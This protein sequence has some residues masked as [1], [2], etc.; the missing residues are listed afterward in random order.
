MAWMPKSQEEPCSKG[1][2]PPKKALLAAA[3]SLVHGNFVFTEKTVE[4]E[5]HILRVILFFISHDFV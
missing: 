5:G 2:E 1:N 3:Q 4:K